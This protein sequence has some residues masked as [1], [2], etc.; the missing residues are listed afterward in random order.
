MS[1][2]QRL[3]RVELESAAD[4]LERVARERNVPLHSTPVDIPDPHIR[5]KVIFTL[6]LLRIL[7][8][9]RRNDGEARLRLSPFRPA[10]LRL[11]EPAGPVGPLI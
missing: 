5:E 3:S 1:A 10:T 4:L 2:W 6:L 8:I 11:G 9:G 7:D